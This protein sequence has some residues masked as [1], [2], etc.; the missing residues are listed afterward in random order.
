MDEIEWAEKT[1]NPLCGCDDAPDSDGD[2]YAARGPRSVRFLSVEPL[3]DT[4]E[5]WRHENTPPSP[6]PHDQD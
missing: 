1:W 4:H 2:C 3:A 6:E 5:E